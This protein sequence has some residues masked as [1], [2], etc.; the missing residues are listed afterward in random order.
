MWLSWAAVD[1]FTA[2]ICAALISAAN[3]VVMSA[4]CTSNVTS[5]GASAGIP[6]NALAKSVLALRPLA[7]GGGVVYA[8]DGRER[9]ARCLDRGNRW[10]G[11]LGLC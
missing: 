10:V 2:G 7:G 5:V 9:D 3:A 11:N 8:A 6:G 1:E 4:F